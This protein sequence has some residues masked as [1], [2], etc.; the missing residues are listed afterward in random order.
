M[1]ISA[2]TPLASRATVAI[3]CLGEFFPTEFFREA[4]GAGFAPVFQHHLMGEPGSSEDGPREVLAAT[5]R[6]LGKA[7]LAAPWGAGCAVSTTEEAALFATAGYTWFTFD[8]AGM[9]DDR[10]GAMSLDQLD[11]AIVALEDGGCF[12][13]GWHETYLDREWHTASGNTLR[14]GDETLARAAVKFGQALAHADQ[15]QQAIRTLWIGRGA[16]PDVELNF[17]ARRTATS[18][19]EFLF[20]AIESARRGLSPVSIAPSLG[21]AWQPGMEFAGGKD[22]LEKM[23]VPL[24]EIAALCGGLK[25]GIHFADG[26]PG[27]ISNT[28]NFSGHLHLNCGEA[29]WLDVLGRLA[30]TQPHRF[31]QW[32]CLAQELF[33]F[34]IGDIPLTISEED[35]H[36]LPEVPDSALREIFLGHVQGRQLLLATF[37]AVARGN[38][39]MRDALSSIGTAPA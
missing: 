38:R 21:P 12:S 3:G 18:A 7:G 15:L 10:V 20:L 33:P 31:R 5:M 29:A 35:T 34:A 23:I 25:V 36:A 30:D 32:L 4:I 39:S 24:C 19:E 9:I 26:K 27:L 13:P 11:A 14:L 17:A 22:D 2:P 8:L 16:S 1:E 37:L 6:A 28:R